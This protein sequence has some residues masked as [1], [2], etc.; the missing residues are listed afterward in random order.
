MTT[1]KKPLFNLNNHKKKVVIVSVGTV[2]VL[3]NFI[4][5]PVAASNGLVLPP[6]T[7]EHLRTA[8]T[9]MLGF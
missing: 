1:K 9:L 2:V 8:A 4:I 7:I 6:V 5:I 3:W